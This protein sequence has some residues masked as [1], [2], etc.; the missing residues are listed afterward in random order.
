MYNQNMGSST[1]PES[2]PRINLRKETPMALKHVASVSVF[3]RNEDEAIDY[4]VKRLGFEL[5]NNAPLGMEDPSLRWVEVGLPG[6]E[7]AIILVRGYAGW[8]EDKVGGFSHIVLR[9]DNIM[10]TYEELKSKGV[11]FTQAPDPQPWGTQAL[12]LDQDGNEFVLVERPD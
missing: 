1:A 2:H 9:T 5:R 8:S 10:G 11:K 12:F 4:Y 3:V 6:A 7:T